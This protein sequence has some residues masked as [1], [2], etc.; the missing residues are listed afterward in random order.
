[1]WS[2]TGLDAV[3]VMVFQERV[4]VV[5]DHVECFLSVI[6]SLYNKLV[7]LHDLVYAYKDEMLIIDDQCV[8][9]FKTLW[10]V[11]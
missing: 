7:L 2:L 10:F 9:T 11:F 6:G 8:V 5:A 3:G 1:M 4:E